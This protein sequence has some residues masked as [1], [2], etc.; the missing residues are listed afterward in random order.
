MN[1]KSEDRGLLI[2]FIVL[3]LICTPLWS[4]GAVQFLPAEEWLTQEVELPYP[5][6]GRLGVE[7]SEELYPARF[8]EWV[9]SGEIKEPRIVAITLNSLGTSAQ[10]GLVLEG[11]RGAKVVESR[12]DHALGLK[13]QTFYTAEK[14]EID[15]LAAHLVLVRKDDACLLYATVNVVIFVFFVIGQM[16]IAYLAGWRTNPIFARAFGAIFK[17]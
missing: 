1:V 17:D 16:I 11:R 13:A 10:Y 12:S 7:I 3:D 5:V 15:G 8:D 2:V 14:V 4:I 6:G 9:K